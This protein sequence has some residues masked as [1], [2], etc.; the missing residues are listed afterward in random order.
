M[1]S[2]HVSERTI[3]VVMAYRVMYGKLMNT[4]THLGLMGGQYI[5][6]ICI[7]STRV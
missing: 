2:A 5:N 6:A 4:S 3:V 7:I 1:A